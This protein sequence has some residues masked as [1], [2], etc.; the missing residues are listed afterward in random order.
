MK[1]AFLTFCAIIITNA[2]AF[3]QAKYAYVILYQGNNAY[4]SRVVDVTT[5][6]CSSIDKNKSN[7]YGEKSMKELYYDCAVSWFT[8]IVSS[9]YSGSYRAEEV[10]FKDPY[11]FYGCTNGNEETCFTSDKA[12][13]ETIRKDGIASAKSIGLNVIEF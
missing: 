1:T 10:F 12:K 9:T 4:V 11:N 6:D 5:L 7:G 8:K 3:G 13:M 2:M